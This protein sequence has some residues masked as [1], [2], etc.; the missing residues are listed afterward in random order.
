V[1]G[2]KFLEPTRV[3]KPD[4]P[5]D[6]PEYYGP[7]DLYIG[8]VV[9]VFKHR[10]IITNADYYVL[11]YLEKHCHQVPGMCQNLSAVL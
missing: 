8:A 4:S 7:Q 5:L 9:E 6:R 1:I 10:F 2:G 3:A 11:K